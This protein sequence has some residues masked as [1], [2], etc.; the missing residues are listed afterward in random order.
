MADLAAR[1]LAAHAT[2]DRAALVGLYQSAAEQAAD[3]DA[4]G[5]FLTH[6]WVYALETGHAAAGPLEHRLRQSGRA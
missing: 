2:E 3:P 1:L 4:A 6:A 5:F